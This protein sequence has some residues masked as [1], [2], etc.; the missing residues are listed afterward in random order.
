MLREEA[1]TVASKYVPVVVGDRVSLRRA[2]PCG[3]HEWVVVRVG[4]DIG[5]RCLTCGRRILLPREEFERRLK[6]LSPAPPEV[7]PE[8][9]N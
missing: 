4:A 7:T 2:H 8:K 9:G 1:R 3:S 6:E 5:L